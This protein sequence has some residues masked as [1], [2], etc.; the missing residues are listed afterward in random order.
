MVL[1]RYPQQSSTPVKP[2]PPIGRYEFA[3]IIPF[4]QRKTGLL[5]RAVRSVLVQ[6][7]V[8]TP[9]VIVVN[10][11]SPV[12][13]EAELGALLSDYPQNLVILT[14]KNKGP[15]SARN[16]GIEFANSRSTYVALLDSDDFWLPN[17]LAIAK[18]VL[19]RGYD[20][21]FSDV[22]RRDNGKTVFQTKNFPRTPFVALKDSP[23]AFTYNGDWVELI[24]SSCPIVI[25][26]LVFQGE[27]NLPSFRTDLRS[28][29]EDHFFFLQAFTAVHNIAFSTSRTVRMGYGISIYAAVQWGTCEHLD[30]IYYNKRFLADSKRIFESNRRY[31]CLF[32]H[33]INTCRR[34]FI[35]SMLSSFAKGLSIATVKTAGAFFKE[36]PTALFWFL[37]IVSWRMWKLIQRYFISVSPL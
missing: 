36:D 17:H 26:A 15:G 19:D 37:P 16:R 33:R 6:R 21:Y 25:S 24:V 9:M 13:P 20:I 31:T 28:A 35:N 12:S 1:I 14:Q 29:G 32:N 22:E 30:Q 5:T 4:F 34:N 27:R 3:V 11:E 18:S 10:D 2:S 7:E 8:P 23:Y